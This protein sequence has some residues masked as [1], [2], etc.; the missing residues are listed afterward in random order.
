MIY[1]GKPEASNVG[2]FMSEGGEE[3]ME[4]YERVECEVTDQSSRFLVKKRD[5]GRQYAHLY[6]ERL[7]TSRPKLI[8]AAKAK[9]DADLP[10]C[11]LHE[12]QSDTRCI[13]VGTLFKH[14]ELKPNILKEISED[15]NLMPQPIRT[16]FT[17][18]SDKLILEDELQRII[19]I[20]HGELSCPNIVTGVI[21]AVLGREPDEDR[22]KFVVEDYCLQALPE[23][24]PRPSL[25]EDR[26]IVLVS[27]LELGGPDERLFSLQLMV[28]LL[29]GQLGD[30][31]QQRDSARI[32]R[33]IIAG[34]SL[35]RSTQDRD[36]LSK[37]KYLTKKSSAGSVEAMKNL[38]DIMFQLSGNVDVAL[39]AGEFDPSN[40]IL[41]QQPLHRCMFPQ[42]AVN[43]TFV[44][45]TNP[46]DCSVDGVRILGT[47]GQPVD[48]IKRY[49]DI[50]DSMDILE[51]TLEW[52]HLAPTAPD[53]LS[54]YP[55]YGQDPFLLEECPHIYFVGNQPEFKHKLHKG[56]GGQ[57][58]LLVTVPRFCQTSTA[59]MVNLSTLEC[60]PLTF[61]AKLPAAS[62]SS[63]E[64]DK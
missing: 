61:H 58:V 40:H 33:I 35:S 56:P 1:T 26:Y 57:E 29:T 13:V 59:V 24:V 42:S 23:Q 27:G 41:P 25:T 62:S 7:W 18:D 12:L 50:D 43:T 60:T 46:H 36:S 54:C 10:V 64:V 45:V 49:S 6:A 31:D 20:G 17:D 8:K 34:N 21:V 55:F 53:T 52:G 15:H 48:D 44:S 63:P 30:G 14:M 38:D 37:A 4:T 9:W 19:L 5:F 32:A 28:D 51:K 2:Q 22:G 47:S 39:M 11:K 3:A 16:R